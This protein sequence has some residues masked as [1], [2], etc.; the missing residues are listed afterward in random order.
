MEILKLEIQSVN[1]EKTIKTSQFQNQSWH[2]TSIEVPM[3]KRNQALVQKPSAP[4]NLG[5]SWWRFW[6]R[7][8]TCIFGEK[9]FSSK[10]FL[11]II[12]ILAVF[13]YED[14]KDED[15]KNKSNLRQFEWFT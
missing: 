12:S 14:C 11:K 7:N 8:E 6:E 9:S 5:A 2:L 13:D 15:A 10:R 4:Q 3:Q 1:F